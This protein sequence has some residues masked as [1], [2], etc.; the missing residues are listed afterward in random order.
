M[1]ILTFFLSLKHRKIHDGSIFS[2]CTLKDGS[3]IS[4]G[5]KDGRLVYFSPELNPTGIENLIEPHFGGV[6]VVAEGKGSQLLVGTTR[7]CILTG[8]LDLGFAP[9]IMGHTDELWG[10]ASHPNMPQFVTGG[11]DRLLQLW[12]SLSHSVVWSKDIGEQVQSCAFSSD[13]EVIAVGGVTGAWLVFDTTTREMLAQHVD[14]NEPIQTIKFS[15]DGNLIAIGSRDNAIYIYQVK[16]GRRFA[17]IGRM[18]GHSSY[19]THID[20]SD[21]S[22]LL[23][24]NSGDYEL[25]Y[26]N[27]TTC[28]QVTSSST[29]RDTEWSTH[30][31]SLTFQTL[32]VWPE[33][34][35]GTDVNT[36][37]RSG[38]RKLVASGDDWG[39]VKLYSYPAAQPKSLA[40]V[41]G[42]HSSHVTSVTFL[43]DDT[44]LISTGGNDT[45]VM[46]WIV[47]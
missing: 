42:G 28:R 19:V 46:Q 10:L 20:W 24:S 23:R 32:G 31:C 2:L 25:L 17:K 45:G 30:T 1:F 12:D 47:S 18:T 8:A 34:A 36:V 37:A 5:G 3:L 15:P 11:K 44:R 6:R 16:D 40:H 22:T 41:Y 13:G 9:V 33:N 38:D 14:G 39:K 7:N 26:W 35:D 27:A 29:L 4:G 21:D 43:H